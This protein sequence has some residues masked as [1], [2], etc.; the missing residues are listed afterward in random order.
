MTARR[1]S[2]AGSTHLG[3]DDLREPVG[4]ARLEPCPRGVALLPKRP[5]ARQPARLGPHR[6]GD[7]DVPVCRSASG[8]HRRRVTSVGGRSARRGARRVA[9]VQDATACDARSRVGWRDP[10]RARP[11][12][13]GRRG[14]VDAGPRDL[15]ARASTSTRRARI[16]QIPD[17]IVVALIDEVTTTLDC[18]DDC[19]G[20][21][22]AR[23]RHEPRLDDGARPMARSR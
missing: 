22:L 11:G 20:V 16:D 12:D 10:H 6:R 21:V 8:R 1:S 3:D 17:A 15:G 4:L 2:S 13:D 19:P 23:H 5:R 9:A 14:A 7:A 18:R